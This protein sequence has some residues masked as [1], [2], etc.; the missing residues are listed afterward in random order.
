MTSL[1][2]FALTSLTSEST[3]AQYDCI[4]GSSTRSSALAKLAAVRGDPSLKRSPRRTVK[5]YLRPLFEIR[6]GP[7]AASGRV[8]SPAGAAA[9]R[10]AV[11]VA[12]VAYHVALERGR[13]S[14]GSSEA[15][16]VGET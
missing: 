8:A 3:Y 14:A 12:Q 16:S 10:N 13:A 2:P 6:G 1:C 9:S 7:S 15:R 11:S 4:A 5:T